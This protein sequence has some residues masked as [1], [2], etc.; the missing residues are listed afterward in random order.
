MVEFVAQPIERGGAQFEIAVFNFR[1]KGLPEL[2][3]KV[4]EKLERWGEDGKSFAAHMSVDEPDSKLE[5][6]AFFG[7]CIACE[8]DDLGV[9]GGLDRGFPLALGDVNVFA[10]GFLNN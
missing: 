8:F 4:A 2:F 3:K 1:I 6:F 5:I 9:I 10:A 7:D